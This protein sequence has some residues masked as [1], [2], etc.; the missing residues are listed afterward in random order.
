MLKQ[1]I[2]STMYYHLVVRVTKQS[3]VEF[4]DL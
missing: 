3:S 2:V 4:Y 1:L